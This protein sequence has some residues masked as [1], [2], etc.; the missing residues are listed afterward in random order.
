MGRPTIHTEN[1]ISFTEFDPV[2]GLVRSGPFKF[3]IN[4][5]QLTVTKKKL[6]KY[7]LT[8]IGYERQA[9][10]ND[11]FMFQYS[12]STGVFRPEET[13]QAAVVPFDLTETKAW[14]KLKEFERFFERQGQGRVRMRLWAEPFEYV[15]S[16]PAFSFRQDAHNPFHIRYDFTFTGVPRDVVPVEIFNI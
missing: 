7:I 13:G 2:T 12:G 11:L 5:D 16:L 1:L 4:P 6:E 9:W 14:Q 15:G 8:K 10:G 3:R